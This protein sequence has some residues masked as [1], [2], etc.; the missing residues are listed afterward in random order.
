MLSRGERLNSLSP[1]TFLTKICMVSS[2]G[3]DE[4]DEVEDTEEMLLE[5]DMVA[6]V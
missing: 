2:A 1:V 6:K 4:A 3:M 5:R